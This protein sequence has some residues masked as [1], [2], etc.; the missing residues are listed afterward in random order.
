LT[1]FSPMPPSRNAS[2]ANF[3]REGLQQ[4]AASASEF[5]QNLAYYQS[6]ARS[7]SAPASAAQSL[8]RLLE[9]VA[10]LSLPPV[11]AVSDQRRARSAANETAARLITAL[12][13]AGAGGGTDA[14]RVADRQRRALQPAEEGKTA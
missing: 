4:R 5:S 11:A 2:L 8:P 9:L 1:W 10:G 3:V 7:R 14:A 12:R 13:C 6:C